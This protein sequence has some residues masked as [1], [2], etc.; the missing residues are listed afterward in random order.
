MMDL[1]PLQMKVKKMYHDLT[2]KYTTSE[3]DEYTFKVTMNKQI[4]NTK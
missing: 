4:K 2:F 3:R 1:Y